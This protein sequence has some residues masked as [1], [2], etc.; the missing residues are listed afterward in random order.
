[1][2]FRVH[3]AYPYA[4]PSI[5][6]N[7]EHLQPIKGESYHF[8][9]PKMTRKNEGGPRSLAASSSTVKIRERRLRAISRQR[10]IGT[11]QASFEPENRLIRVK[12]EP[13]S[14]LSQSEMEHAI[15]LPSKEVAGFC[16]L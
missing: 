12:T 13:L 15:D 16:G 2:L 14:A 5:E 1:V 4:R 10:A 7:F 9:A 3:L 6:I 11:R 8:I